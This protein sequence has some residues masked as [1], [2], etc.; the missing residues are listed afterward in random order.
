MEPN[1]WAVKHK[2][3]VVEIVVEF[4]GKSVGS[5][6]CVGRSSGRR[7]P[8]WVR[9]EKRSHWDNRYTLIDHVNHV[10]LVAEQDRPRTSEALEQGLCGGQGWQP[11]MLP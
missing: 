7:A 8:L 1:L 9:S 5:A 3:D 11:S 6:R 10:L 4:E 2:L